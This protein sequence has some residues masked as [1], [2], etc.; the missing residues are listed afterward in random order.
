MEMQTPFRED[1][2]L[3]VGN[4]ARE[5]KRNLAIQE[6]SDKK[7][8]W[9]DIAPFHPTTSVTGLFW[10]SLHLKNGVLYRKWESDDGKTFRGFSSALDLTIRG[11]ST[12]AL[13]SKEK[14]FCK[15][16]LCNT[17][18][19]NKTRTTALHLQSVGMVKEVQSDR[20]STASLLVTNNQLKDSDKKLP[21]FF[22]C[23]QKCRS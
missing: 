6:L 16:T 8:S 11:P 13:R 20:F 17:R 14:Q 22:S 19:R 2:V 1:L 18:H 7:P 12:T 10:D 3:T 9:Q 21:F 15:K 23:R 4:T 5:S